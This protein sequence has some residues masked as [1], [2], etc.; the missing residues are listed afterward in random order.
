MKLVVEYFF[1][2]L[3]NFIFFYGYLVF[4]LGVKICLKG[5]FLLWIVCDVGLVLLR[6]EESI[7]WVA[8]SGFRFR[9]FFFSYY[10]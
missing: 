10:Y 4:F 3:L 8:S 2:V 7:F 9:C 1:I 5:G 6:E